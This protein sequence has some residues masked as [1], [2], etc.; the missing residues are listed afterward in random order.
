[1]N[2]QRQLHERLIAAFGFAHTARNPKLPQEDR[3]LIL[4]WL[5]EVIAEALRLT[6]T[7]YLNTQELA[8]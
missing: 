5:V 8:G 6:P 2:R 4:A 3:E 7:D 1:M